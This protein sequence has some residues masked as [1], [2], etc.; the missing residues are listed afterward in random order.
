[1]WP[2]LVTVQWN[3]GLDRLFHIPEH[4]E[5][6][7]WLVPGRERPKSYSIPRLFH[8]RLFH[9]SN[10]TVHT[11]IKTPTPFPKARFAYGAQR[12]HQLEWMLCTPG[13]RILRGT[14]KVRGAGKIG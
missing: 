3:I 14:S 11:A 7:I 13:L 1:M 4:G 6:N 10:S 5:W 9:T 2:F 12:T 8:M